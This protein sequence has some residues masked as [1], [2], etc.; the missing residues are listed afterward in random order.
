[1]PV[2]PSAI[3][4][5]MLLLSN[6]CLLVSKVTW[7]FI[8]SSGGNMRGAG[9][10]THMPSLCPQLRLLLLSGFR[11]EKRIESGQEVRVWLAVS[12]ALP[13]PLIYAVLTALLN[14]NWHDIHIFKVCNFVSCE[15]YRYTCIPTVKW[16]TSCQG[17]PML[18]CSLSLWFLPELHP[19][20]AVELL[21]LTTD[22]FAF[23]RIWYE[24]YC[25]ACSF[26]CILSLNMVFWDSS[27]HP[28]CCVYQ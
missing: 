22:E 1:M 11:K 17:F 28:C 10:P 25:I 16:Q 8:A 24:L 3:Q 21:S 15:V 27:M 2:Y 7:H 6:D 9:N 18:L 23:F 5:F 13:N 12:S 19:H 4:I 20:T 14:D 26:F